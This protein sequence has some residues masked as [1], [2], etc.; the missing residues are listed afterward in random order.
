MFD[1]PLAIAARSIKMLLEGIRADN[2]K[3]AINNFISKYINWFP[4]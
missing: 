2:L 1:T 4:I 3:N